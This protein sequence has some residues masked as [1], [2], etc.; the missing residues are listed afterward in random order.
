MYPNYFFLYPLTYLPNN[1]TQKENEVLSNYFSQNIEE[2]EKYYLKL[3]LERAKGAGV[4]PKDRNILMFIIRDVVEN[5]FAE[6]TPDNK[7][8]LNLV[9]NSIEDIY[10]DKIYK[11]IYVVNREHRSVRVAKNIN[12]S[13]EK[14][15]N[16]ILYDTEKKIDKLYKEFNIK[17]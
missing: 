2:A 5:H 15:I 6:Y 3:S 4:S 9:R 12:P 8:L 16:N 14:Q 13:L 7:G 17:D 11:L 10:A 1:L